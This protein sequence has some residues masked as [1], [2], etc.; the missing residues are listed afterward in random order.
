KESFNIEPES[1]LRQAREAAAVTNSPAASAA[2]L[3]GTRPPTDTIKGAA[4]LLQSSQSSPAANV[5]LP[6][7][8]ANPGVAL[9]K[10][11]TEHELVLEEMERRLMMSAPASEDDLRE[12]MQKRCLAVEK[13]LL[14]TGKVTAERVLLVAPKPVD[15]AL[16][17]MALST[18]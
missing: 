2:T 18:V 12:L 7:A 8:S 10:P 15:P 14:D 1:A 4:R 6:N 13:L 5:R 16:K 9:A 11:K 17:V 3:S